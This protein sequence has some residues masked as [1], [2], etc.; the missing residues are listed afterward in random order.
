MF[1]ELND[2]RPILQ[3][4]G[5]ILLN[6][7]LLDEHPLER[8][9]F[10]VEAFHE[11]VFASIYNLYQSGIQKLDDFAIDQFLS[12]Y[13]TQYKIF[14][15]NKGLEWINDA[16]ALLLQTIKKTELSPIFEEK[17]CGHHISLQSRNH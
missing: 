8:E 7:D 17:G 10:E 5:C 12:V 15:D 3:V 2:P 9:D 1:A 16:I 11:I 6:P 14:N 13:P 4:I